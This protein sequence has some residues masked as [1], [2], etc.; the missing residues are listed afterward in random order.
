MIGPDDPR[1]RESEQ[2][3]RLGALGFGLAFI[4]YL[5]QGVARAWAEG[6][7]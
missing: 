6:R 4:L 5:A 2:R 7:L 1:Q 3:L